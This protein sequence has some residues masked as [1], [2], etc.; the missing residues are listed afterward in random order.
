MSI[1]KLGLLALLGVVFGVGFLIVVVKMGTDLGAREPKPQAALEPFD[2]KLSIQ[3]VDDLRVAGRKIV[4]CGVAFTKPQS[5]RAM[6]TEA[7]RRD[8]QG[9]ALTCKP[10]GNGTPCDGNVAS[11]FG[12][13]IVVQC[14]T[15]DGADLAAK[16]AENGILC[17]QPA[18]AGSIYKSCLSGS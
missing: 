3:A 16:L 17:G 14:L 2:G 6:V 1:K 12:D 4:L 11:K 10:V 13:A 8:Y 9:L 7:A 18:Q 5:M 15:S